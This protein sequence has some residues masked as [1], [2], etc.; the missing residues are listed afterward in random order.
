M[1]CWATYAG[2]PQKRVVGLCHSV[3]NTTRE[4][5]ELRRRPVRGGH[6][7]RRRRQPPGVHPALRARR[8]EP[9]PAARRGDRAR[10]RAAAP[11]PGP[12]VPAAR[13]LPDRVERALGRVPARGSCT[14][15]RRSSAYRIGSAS[16]SRAARRTSPSTSAPAS[17]SP[18]GAPLPIEPSNEYAPQIIHSIETGT[19]RVIYGNVRNTGLIDEPA[20]RRLRRGPVP[21]R[22]HRRAADPR[23][24]AAAA[25]ARRSI[26]PSS[27]SPS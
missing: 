2:T 18:P 23:R 5:A 24:R 27:T 21:G 10:P 22:R 8:R 4:L 7:P 19:P 26:G 20:R 9:L 13:L 16:T 17:C 6:L 14:T 11:G 3:Q 1:L 15:T 12:D 25:A